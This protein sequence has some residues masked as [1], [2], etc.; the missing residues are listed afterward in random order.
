MS[1]C[2]DQ[3]TDRAVGWAA[4]SAA[5]AALG[6]AFLCIDGEFRVVHASEWLDRMF[7]AGTAKAAE[8]QRLQDLFGSDLF[9]EGG[10]L[11]LALSHGERREGW[12]AMFT[13][14]H[15]HHLVSLSAAPFPRDLATAC[16]PRVEYVL[17]VRTAAEDSED[18]LGAPHAMGGLIARSP[19][20]LRVFSLVDTLRHSEAPVLITGESGTGKELIARAVH[21]QSPRSQGPFVAVSGGAL[22]SELLESEMFGHTRGSFTG[23]IRDRIGRFEA[24]SKGTLFLDEVGDLPL[25]LQVK[26]LRVL[27]DGTFERVGENHTRTSHARVIAA[28]NMD[29]ARAVREGRFRKDLYFRIR[30]VPIEIAPLRRRREDI[31]PI[32]RALLGRIGARNGRSLQ[33]S[34]DTLRVLLLHDWPGNVRELENAIEFAVAVCDGQTILPDH[35]PDLAAFDL[36]AADPG[37]RAEPAVEAAIPRPAA[38]AE[39]QDSLRSALDANQ[40]R[41]DNTAR[42]LGISR[43]TLWRRMRES[44]LLQRE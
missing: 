40:W 21:D 12:R 15:T 10:V 7:G 29:L 38:S 22:P 2:T 19:A 1:D 25:S 28:T 34:P 32:A 9:G 31:E 41:R 13:G 6:R 27:Q 26:L 39:P 5:F 43:I 17:V 42:A 35:L 8:E 33:F 37:L 44:G 16:D 20:M 23:A 14:T 4:V 3:T 30:V 36:A 18:P 24:A 11:R